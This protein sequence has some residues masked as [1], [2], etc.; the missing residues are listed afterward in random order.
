METVK[1]LPQKHAN[2]GLAAF[3][4]YFELEAAKEVRN[5]DIKMKVYILK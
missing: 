3:I 4:D 1:L 5:A 2:I